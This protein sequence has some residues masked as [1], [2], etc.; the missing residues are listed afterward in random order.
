M[1]NY[2]QNRNSCILEVVELEEGFKV[3]YLDVDEEGLIKI[4]EQ[5]NILKKKNH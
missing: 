4:D 5:E 3:T 1:S 2:L